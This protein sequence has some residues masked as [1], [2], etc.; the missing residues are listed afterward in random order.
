[1]KVTLSKER[2][3]FWLVADLLPQVEVNRHRRLR[4][5]SC[6]L[7]SL[8]VKMSQAYRAKKH[9]A[10]ERIKEIETF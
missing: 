2:A 1:M 7:F 9:K 10:D 6:C 5:E 3:I 8:L 4:K